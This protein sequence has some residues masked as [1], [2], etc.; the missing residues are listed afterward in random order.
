MSQEIK[1]PLNKQLKYSNY[2]LEDFLIVTNIFDPK[3]H[4]LFQPN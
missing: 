4:D 1:L 3:K 2:Y